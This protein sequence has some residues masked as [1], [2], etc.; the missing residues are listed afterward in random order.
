MI[1]Q[2]TIEHDEYIMKNI[3]WY[4][5]NIKINVDKYW[6]SRKRKRMASEDPYLDTNKE[7]DELDE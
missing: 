2:F 3:T 1:T 4:L 6:R 5:N 7:N